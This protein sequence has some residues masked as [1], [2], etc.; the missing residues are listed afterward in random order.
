MTQLTIHEA[1][2]SLGL[3]PVTIRRAWREGRLTGSKGPG[4]TSPILIDQ[5]SVETYRRLHLGKRGAIPMD[6]PR[7]A[8]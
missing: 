7:R 1:A 2:A 8:V 4:K 5:S 6:D 3:R